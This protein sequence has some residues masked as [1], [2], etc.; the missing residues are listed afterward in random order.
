MEPRR[1]AAAASDAVPPSS[2]P[3]SGGSAAVRGL[4]LLMVVDRVTNAGAPRPV[5]VEG[6]EQH[7]RKGPTRVSL[8]VSG[9]SQRLNG[10]RSPVVAIFVLLA[11][12]VM[13]NHDDDEVGRPRA[14]I[15]NFTQIMIGSSSSLQPCGEAVQMELSSGAAFQNVEMSLCTPLRH[16]LLRVRCACS[17]RAV[18]SRWLG[19][20]E[21]SLGGRQ[22]L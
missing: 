11:L 9:L 1:T 16:L 19:G 8:F 20:L 7:R 2:P 22:C 4:C 17:Q 6:S 3:G 5:Q 21:G 14:A 12:W 15:E 10:A 13:M 18:R